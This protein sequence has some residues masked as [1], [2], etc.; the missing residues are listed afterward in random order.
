[1]YEFKKACWILTP[2]SQCFKLREMR[3]YG[4]FKAPGSAQNFEYFCL[5]LDKK[6][7]SDFNSAIAYFTKAF[8]ALQ[9][10]GLEEKQKLTRAG[11]FWKTSLILIFNYIDVYLLPET[12]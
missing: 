9:T 5:A 11:K 1:M 10:D 7:I 3:N 8:Y 2:W 12:L 6:K 4:T